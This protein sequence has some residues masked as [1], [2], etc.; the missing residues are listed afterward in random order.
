[1]NI[2]YLKKTMEKPILLA[3]AALMM[4]AAVGNDLYGTRELRHDA[5]LHST[6]GQNEKEYDGNKLLV[7][8]CLYEKEIAMQSPFYV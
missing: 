1:M 3:V 4:V 2:S 6:D 8:V 5:T 7:I